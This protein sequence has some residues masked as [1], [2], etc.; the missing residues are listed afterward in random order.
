MREGSPRRVREGSPRRALHCA[1]VLEAAR[2]E[3]ASLMMRARRRGACWEEDALR[4]EGRTQSRLLTS[5]PAARRKRSSSRRP[6]YAARKSDDDSCACGARQMTA[7]ELQKRGW[8]QAAPCL[9]RVCSGGAAQ[10]AR[11]AGGGAQRSTRA[12][13]ADAAEAA[14]GSAWQSALRSAC[15]PQVRR[16][17]AGVQHAARRRRRG[18]AAEA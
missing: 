16:G 14:G 4:R 6:L 18:R 5:A 17:A 2:A 7:T 9:G 8:Q 12:R 3:R 13:G 1:A 15:W 10:R 11:Q